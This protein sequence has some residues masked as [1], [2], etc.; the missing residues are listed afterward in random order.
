[1]DEKRRLLKKRIWYSVLAVFGVLVIVMGGLLLDVYLD[2]KREGFLDKQEQKTYDGTSIDNMRAL[3]GALMLYYA[4]EG[5]MPLASG[6]MDAA[7][8]YVHTADLLEGEAL[9][10][11]VNPN[12]PA[13]SGV[14]GYA[15]NSVLS[16][17]YIDEVEDPGNTVMIFDSA[18]TSWNAHGSPSEMAPS[19]ELPG[20][21]RAITV[22]GAIVKL[23][24]PIEDGPN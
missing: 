14:F 18:D 1:M 24:D 20:G 6:W 22:E 15:M 3:H 13:G 11:F 8:K 2:F 17:V 21:N 19:P 12:L 9:K 7:E 5:A 23:S 4:D 10:K 16:Q